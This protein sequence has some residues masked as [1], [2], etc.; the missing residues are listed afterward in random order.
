[1]RRIISL[2]TMLSVA[3]VAWAAEPFIVFQPQDNALRITSAKIIVEKNEHACVQHAVNNLTTDLQ[4]VTGKGRVDADVTILI[5]T[6]GTNKQI[7]QWVRKGVL[8]DLKGKIEKYIIKTIDNQLVIAGSDKR[9]TVFGIYELSQQIGVSPWYYWA[10]VLIIH[11]DELFVKSGEYTDGE[12]NVRY[13]GLFLNDE[14]PCLTTWVK[15]T[16]GTDYGGHEFYEKVFELIL[17]LKGNFLWP[18]MW[19]WA[20]YADDP[21]NSKLADQMGIIIG[22]SHHEP[23]ARNHQEWARH[24]REYGAWNYDTNQQVLDRFFREGIER[25]KHTDDI[26]TI[27]MRGDGDEAM[28]KDADTKLLEKIVEN[29][30]KIIKEVT[31][32]PAKETTQVWALYKEV[33]DY[34]DKGMRVPDDVLI[35]LCDDNWGDIRRV[36]NLKERQHPGGW[37]L[38]YHVDYVGAPRN[39]KWL[40]VTPSQN[41]WEQLTLASDYGLDRMWV[42]NVGD[43]KPMEYPITLFMDMAWNPRSVSPDVVSTHTRPFCVQQF[44]EDQADEAARIL[45]LCCKLAGRSTAEMLDARTYNVKTGEWNQVANEYMRLEAEA[46]RQYLTLQPQ[47]RDAYQQ[48][49]LFP[50]QAMSNIYQMYYAQAMNRWLYE[51]GDAECNVWADRVAEAFHRD[52]LLC[53]SYNH[54]IAGGKWNGMMIQKHIGY[55]SWNDNFP[56]DI[57]PRTSRIEEPQAGG[58]TFEMQ[59]GVVVMEAEHYYESKA[60]PNTQWTV[61]PFMGRTRSAMTLMPYTEGNVKGSSL[62]YRFHA[63]QDKKMVRVRVVTK[64]TL[65]Y[66]NKGGLTFTVQL[67]N[68]EPQTVNFNQR[69]NENPENIHSVYY[70]TVARRVVESVVTLPAGSSA[71]VHSLTLSPQDPAIVFEKVIVEAEGHEWQPSYLFGNESDYTRK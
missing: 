57:L 56:R 55:R 7:D 61:I 5:G 68:G 34:Y 37:G 12:P 4:K 43:L 62:T 41:M 10:D 40:N 54:D 48:I 25:M 53:A 8:P 64:S 42:L 69:L 46:L 13:R 31:G 6:L 51:K 30:R 66:L 50:V 36:P 26:V 14:A 71:D 17:R 24:R 11:R 22:T 3:F 29:Q 19:G 23:M 18:A 44:G 38:Y 58:F 20:F 67:D 70:P 33:L 16:F 49:I 60:A 47:Y 65:D 28:S 52:S 15:N 45:N 59:G 2:F 9:G 35:L 1:M 63:P 32:R 21:E 27:G 39:S